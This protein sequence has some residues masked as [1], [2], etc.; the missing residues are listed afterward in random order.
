MKIT[1]KSVVILRNG[2]VAGHLPPATGV[3]AAF[4]PPYPHQPAASPGAGA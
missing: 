1:Q 2:P 3:V 4:A